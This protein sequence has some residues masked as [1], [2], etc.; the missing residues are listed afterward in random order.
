VWNIAIIT[1]KIVGLSF[2]AAPFQE[3]FGIGDVTMYYTA[4]VPADDVAQNLR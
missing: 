3:L 1:A 4:A 2:S